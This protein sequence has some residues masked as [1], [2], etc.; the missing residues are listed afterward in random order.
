MADGIQS[1]HHNIPKP[2]PPSPPPADKTGSERTKVAGHSS[3]LPPGTNWYP[4]PSRDYPLTR[5]GGNTIWP[6]WEAAVEGSGFGPS[7][8]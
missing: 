8:G 2:R 7:L 3:S 4:N 6:S 5:F 1:P